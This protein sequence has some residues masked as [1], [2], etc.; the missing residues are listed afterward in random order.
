MLMNLCNLLL[1]ISVVVFVSC[2]NPD[3]IHLHPQNPHYFEWKDKPTILVT[4]AEH[5]GA[6]LNLDFDFD[7]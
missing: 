3:P 2:T 6:V 1:F 4:S 7:P 5:Y